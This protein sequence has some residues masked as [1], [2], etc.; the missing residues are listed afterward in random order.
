LHEV[1]VQLFR[2]RP[3]LAPELLE[4]V[5]HLELP[6][7]SEVRIGSEDVTELQPASYRADLVVL[8]YEGE[9]VLAIIVEVQLHK[10]ER[11]LDTWLWYAAGTRARLRCD[12]VVLVV[13]PY[14]EVARWAAEPVSWSAGG[15]SFTPLVIGP[16][17][18]PVITDLEVAKADPELAVLSAMA[19]GQD[20]DVDL[21][22]RIAAA[23][24]AAAVHLDPD[25]ALLYYDLV[26]ASL[27]EAARESLM[28]IQP[29]GYEFQ[30]DFAKQ[31]SKR[32]A[33]GR[34]EGRQE[35]E[36]RGEAR[37]RASTVLKLLQLKF[38]DLPADVV[39]CIE[40]GSL[41]DLDRWAERIL[42]IERLEDLFD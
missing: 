12:A 28:S 24:S 17:G 15:A 36:A 13:T 10:D 31:W 40:T 39:T 29:D 5:L 32:V 42:F 18:V 34:Q 3:E 9:P 14:E 26:L 35:G 30:S 2:N 19:H 21:A 27:S 37:G 25:R 7:F 6:A 4:Q 23:A 41:E 22:A 8:L 11:K 33:Q 38:G 1:L 16:R 20:A